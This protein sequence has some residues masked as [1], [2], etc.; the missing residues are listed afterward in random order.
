MPLPKKLGIKSNSV[1]ALIDAPDDF[2]NTLGNLPANVK[3]TR[4]SGA[5]PDVTLWFVR[6]KA[7]LENKIQ[8]M[9]PY[10]DN[11]MLWIIWPKK[12]SGVTSDLAQTI[13]R[14]TGL[15]VGLVDFKICSVDTT[16]SG[17]VFTKRKNK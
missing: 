5:N 13:V 6:S 8:Y 11:A 7:G 3:F 15:A 12:G 2:E 16:W 14:K 1:V 4:K 17:L 9:I 10:A